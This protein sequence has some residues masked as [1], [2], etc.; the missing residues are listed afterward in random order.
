MLVGIQF[1]YEIFS[2][3]VEFKCYYFH[4]HIDLSATGAYVDFE[5]RVNTVSAQLKLLV[6]KS[7][8][9]SVAPAQ[10]TRGLPT[11][12]KSFGFMNFILLSLV[13]SASVACN[14]TFFTKL[15]SIQM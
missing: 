6:Q 2:V 11:T 12:K 3:T 7:F 1:M 14:L 13:T 8:K 5:G 9:R 15:L 4:I 10:Y